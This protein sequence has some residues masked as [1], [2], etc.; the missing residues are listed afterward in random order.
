MNDNMKRLE[1][2]TVAAAEAALA[3]QQFVTAIDVFQGIGWLP[4]ARV[5]EWRQG[6]LPYLER[7]VSTNLHKISAVMRMFRRWAQS[8]GLAPR[9]MP[10]VSRTRDRH[11]L[12]FSKTG[13]LAIERAYRTH[14]VS[15]ELSVAK[16]ER[17]AERQGRAPDLVVI[18]PVN[19]WT[20]SKCGGTGDLLTMDAT[21]PLCLRCAKL[22]HL[23]YLPAGDAALS[24][25]AKQASGLSAIVV[26]FSRS[27]KHYER[28][29]ILIEESA[30][31]QAEAVA[32]RRARPHTATPQECRGLST[33]SA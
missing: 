21:G 20:C 6:R 23:V 4:Q 13:E 14:W 31:K 29:G 32:D 1:A 8:R 27:R 2:R 19:E 24:R 10:Y 26:R 12:R 30:L 5:D 22:D 3:R 9:E 17:L 28:Q 7:G 33:S 18:S 16:Q 15:A 25:R 11:Q